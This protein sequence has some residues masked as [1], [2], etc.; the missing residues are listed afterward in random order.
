MWPTLKPIS[1]AV[2]AYQLFEVVYDILG[3]FDVDINRTIWIN[4]ICLGT[5]A[6]TLTIYR[7]K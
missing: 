7:K 4:I 2:I 1:A 6:I 3:T 5:I